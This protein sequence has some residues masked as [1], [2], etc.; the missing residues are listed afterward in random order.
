MYF[1]GFLE[2]DYFFLVNS[3]ESF[4]RKE[5][6]VWFGVVGVNGDYFSYLGFFEF[7][8]YLCFKL[9]LLEI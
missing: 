4:G 7:Y 3:E 8:F 6:G 1:V 2:G 5:I 9:G